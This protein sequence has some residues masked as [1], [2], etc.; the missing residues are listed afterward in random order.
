MQHK[1]LSNLRFGHLTV[2]HFD[3]KTVVGRHPENS[4]TIEEQIILSHIM[5]KRKVL[6]IGVMN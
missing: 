6:P 3:H 2:L 1:D 5:E 4:Q